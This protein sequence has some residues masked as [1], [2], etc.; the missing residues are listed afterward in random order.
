MAIRM[1]T[2]CCGCN[3]RTGIMLIGLFG[4]FS[5]GV[6]IYWNHTAAETGELDALPISQGYKKVLADLSMVALA[7]SA[8]SM[9][10]DVFLLI[11][12][13]MPSRYLTHSWII[14]RIFV[15]FGS[16]I[17]NIFLMS[18]WE[19]FLF[20]FCLNIYAWLLMVY[21]ILVV[22]SYIDTPGPERTSLQMSGSSHHQYDGLA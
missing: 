9:L 16:F 19:G 22:Y 6:G 12:Y 3:L 4:I 15:I 10:A 18:V 7:F 21:F 20:L 17:L 11:S 8:V 1:Q 13:C 5:N 2:F 14:W